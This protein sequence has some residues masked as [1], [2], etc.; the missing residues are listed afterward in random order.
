M[1]TETVIVLVLVISAFAL[2]GATL[3]WGSNLTDSR[4]RT[5]RR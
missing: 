1:P 3:A 4:L 5:L 2:F